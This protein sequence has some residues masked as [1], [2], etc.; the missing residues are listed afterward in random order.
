MQRVKNI[1]E[2]K[3]CNFAYL[4]QNYKNIMPEVD[5]IMYPLTIAIITAILCFAIRIVFRRGKEINYKPYSSPRAHYR[6]R[7]VLPLIFSSLS[8]AGYG[9]YHYWTI[10][11]GRY[12]DF[13]LIFIII[14]AVFFFQLFVG[15]FARTWKIRKTSDETI[16]SSFEP[17]V[18]V[19]VYNEDVNSL[20]ET[21]N[22][23][24]MQTRVPRE[25]HVV[26][27]GSKEK[28]EK[29]KKWFEN[30]AKDSEITVTWTRHDKNQGK[31]AAHVTALSNMSKELKN[32]AIIIT[33][34]SDGV[35]D[36]RAIEQGLIPFYDE[37]IQSVAGVMISRNATQNLL[38]RIMDWTFV[39][40]ALVD[41]S[42][43]SVFGNVLVNSGALA[44]YRY[45]V[46]QLAKEV[47][48]TEEYFFGTKVEFSDDS[49]L[50]L[51]ALQLG[52]AV[53][54]PSAIVFADMPSNLSHHIRQQIRWSRGSFIRSWWRLR[55]LDLISFGWIR[56]LIGHVMFFATL[57]IYLQILII[58]PFITGGSLG[59]DLCILGIILSYVHGMRYF[60]IKRNDMTVASQ[61][62][63]YF[64]SPVAILWSMTVLKM[65]KLYSYMTCTNSRWGTRQK[66][67]IV[68][69]K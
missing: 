33:V 35:L 46:F 49:Y 61:F 25:V 1:L 28:Y 6:N 53:Y 52:K 40:Q 16:V 29:I 59:L 2:K 23:I 45:G 19:P 66:V 9:F 22:S 67:E 34:D 4:K 68:H 51:M 14:G 7:V 69:K 50:T 55:Y 5:S 63:V 65:I 41:R 37:E 48:Y 64:L 30:A 8:L 32:D 18:L 26:D 13:K 62:L 42:T 57:T 39:T 44:F 24:L 3:G 21:L 11:H 36:K 43:M 60:A 31:R 10:A 27:D 38:T 54:Q 17:V 12:N 58:K 20:K 47:G 15:I 56:Q